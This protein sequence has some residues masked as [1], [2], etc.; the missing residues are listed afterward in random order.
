MASVCS[1]NVRWNFQPN[2]QYLLAEE[3]ESPSKYQIDGQ[4]TSTF[5]YSVVRPPISWLSTRGISYYVSLIFATRRT[6]LS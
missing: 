2:Q 4:T 3:I 1:L 6:A 5:D